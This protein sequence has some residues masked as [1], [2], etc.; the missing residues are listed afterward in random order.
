MI[1]K[2]FLSIFILA[3]FFTVSFAEEGML[4]PSV[5]TA[6]ES[7]MQAMGMK[8][9]ANDIY[10][11][12]N[13]SI[14]DAIIHFGGGCTAELVSGQGLILTNHHCGYSQIQSHSSLEK[15]YLKNGF[16]A[17]NN[18]EELQN[19]GLTA[20]RMVRIDDVTASVFWDVN[21]SDDIAT[22]L[23]KIKKKYFSVDCKC[24]NWESLR[25]RN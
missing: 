3:S 16:W 10:D 19:S 18:S 4:V 13:S 7:E 6:F 23:A 12:N 9:S 17:K 22:R 21:T 2:I 24:K 14:K 15:D 5:I 8:L 11:V 25:G 1:K 20:T